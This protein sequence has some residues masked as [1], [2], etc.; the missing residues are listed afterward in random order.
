MRGYSAV[1][2]RRS[3]FLMVVFITSLYFIPLCRCG[4]VNVPSRE[5]TFVLCSSIDLPRQSFESFS[6]PHALSVTSFNN[7]NFPLVQASKLTIRWKP[8]IKLAKNILPVALPPATVIATV[9][10]TMMAIQR[11]MSLAV[12]FGLVWWCGFQK[13]ECRAEQQKEKSSNPLFSII[14]WPLYSHRCL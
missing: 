12:S 6:F 8:V 2:S 13:R 11:T 1:F 9:S 5:C 7:C 14:F 4:R 10:V 3:V